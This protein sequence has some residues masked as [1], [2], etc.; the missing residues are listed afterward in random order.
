MLPAV[1]GV[2]RMEA[3]RAWR[4]LRRFGYEPSDLRQEFRLRLLEVDGLYNPGRSSPATFASHSCRQRTLQLVEPHLA[5]K[6]NS[7]MAMQSLSTPVGLDEG[8]PVELAD[9]IADDEYAMRIGRRSRPATELAAL[10]LDVDRV[11]SGLPIELADVARLL[12]AGNSVV[13]LARRLGIS[14]ATA[15]RRIASLREAFHAAG[16]DSYNRNR[17]AA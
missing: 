11:V 9:L 7:G 8:S 10:R 4:A 14:R 6:R 15:H 13:A 17:E 16:L 5:A 3:C 12:A 2:I 1:L